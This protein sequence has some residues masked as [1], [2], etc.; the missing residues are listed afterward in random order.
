MLRFKICE[1]WEKWGQL[2]KYCC[3]YSVKHITLRQTCELE[4]LLA[5]CKRHW[6]ESAQYLGWIFNSIHPDLLQQFQNEL[7][8]SESSSLQHDVV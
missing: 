1:D 7:V 6:A 2:D 5:I 4:N 8:V 3:A